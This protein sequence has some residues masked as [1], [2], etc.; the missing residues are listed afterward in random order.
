MGAPEYV[1]ENALG[2]YLIERLLELDT[3]SFRTFGA[4][5]RR[6]SAQKTLAEV[7]KGF[8]AHSSVHPLSDG[9]TCD[10]SLPS[11][12]ASGRAIYRSC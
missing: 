2:F 3:L 5:L 9:S 11:L 4:D 6:V 7:S 8:L 1:V 12:P 10:R